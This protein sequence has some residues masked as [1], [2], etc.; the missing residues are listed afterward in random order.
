MQ[1]IKQASNVIKS[2]RTTEK[3]YYRIIFFTSIICYFLICYFELWRC[4]MLQVVSQGIRLFICF[5]EL[6]QNERIMILLVSHNVRT[7]MS[8]ARVCC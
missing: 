6:S 7:D 5:E 2:M 3:A 8:Q 4:C 1:Q